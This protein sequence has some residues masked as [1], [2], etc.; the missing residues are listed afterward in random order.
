MTLR[1]LQTPLRPFRLRLVWDQVQ[2]VLK[3]SEV[4]TNNREVVIKD[5]MM[6]VIIV[7]VEVEIETMLTTMTL[8]ST[9]IS[10]RIQRDRLFHMMTSSENQSH[11]RQQLTYQSANI[12]NTHFNSK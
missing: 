9:N 6:G 7:E 8:L 1:S 11:F 12:F 10:F 2:V 4:D 5:T 3:G